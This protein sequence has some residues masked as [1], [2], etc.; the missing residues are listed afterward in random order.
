[1][2]FPHFLVS[3]KSLIKLG[4][5]LIINQRLWHG[6]NIIHADY[7]AGE[8]DAISNTHI[9]SEYREMFNFS[10]NKESIYFYYTQVHVQRLRYGYLK[11]FHL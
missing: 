5:L 6:H 11:H 10:G 8:I 2:I 3:K 9:K 4:I 1:M 7:I